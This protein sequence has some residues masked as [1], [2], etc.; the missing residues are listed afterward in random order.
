MHG[1]RLLQ[2]DG[3]P[4]GDDTFDGEFIGYNLGLPIAG[5][6]YDDFHMTTSFAPGN[7]F[8]NNSWDWLE[9]IWLCGGDVTAENAASYA[10]GKARPWCWIV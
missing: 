1:R 5:K 4:V 8:I 7:A 10:A 9:N 6:E 2:A 3:Y